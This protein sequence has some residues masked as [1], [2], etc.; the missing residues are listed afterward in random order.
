MMRHRKK[1]ARRQ[2]RI[3]QEAAEQARQYK[4][5]VAQSQQ[6][7]RARLLRAR[8][9]CQGLQ[10]GVPFQTA[11]TQHLP[12]ST[13]APGRSQR[14]TCGSVSSTLLLLLL[15]VVHGYAG[16]T[17]PFIPPVDGIRTFPAV[18]LESHRPVVQQARQSEP[19]GGLGGLAQLLSRQSAPPE[20]SPSQS[21]AT[22]PAPPPA[23]AGQS[24]PVAPPVPPPAPPA[25][26]PAP[27]G[28]AS[29]VVTPVPQPPPP[30][31]PAPPPPPPPPPPPSAPPQPTAGARLAPGPSLPSMTTPEG[32]RYPGEGTT[33]VKD[34]QGGFTWCERSDMT[35]AVKAQ[36]K[37]LM[38]RYDKVFARSLKDLGC[39]TGEM[40]PARIE[41]VHDR[42]IWQPQRQHS[43][44]ELQIQ[45]EKCA[46]LRDAGII[47]PS[48]STKYAMNVTM[49]AKKDANGQWTDRRYCCDARP[50]NAATVPN[51][52][53][54]PTP[55]QLFQ[56][57]GGSP[58]ISKM[59]CRAAFNQI[60]L[61]REDQEKT[62]F[63]WREK[64]W[65]YTRNLY[66][67]RNATGQFQM[68]IDHEL[69][70]HGLEGF[71]MAFVDDILVFS[72]TAE[73]H[74]QHCE[75]VFRCLM[76]CGL[77]LHPEKTI[78]AAEEVEFL[79]HMCSAMGVRPMDAKCAAIMA[80]Q[81]PTN[82]T[83]LQA[84]LGLCNYYR[85]Y[86]PHFS[87]IA[88]PLNQLTRKGI[89]WGEQTWQ[90]EHQAVLDA[91]KAHF[92]Q[93]GLILRRLQPG[94]PIILHTDFSAS[95][96]SGVLGQ[97]D[98]DGNEY[99]VA[100]VSRSLN[101]HERNYISY[102]GEMR[103]ACW[104][105]QAMRP[106]LH[107]VQFTLVTDH[108]PLLWLMENTGA[109]S[110]GVYQRWQLIMSQYDFNITHRPGALHQNADAL[111]RMPRPSTADGTGSRMDEEDDPVPPKPQLVPY[112]R[113]LV[114]GTAA[115]LSGPI[116]VLLTRSQAQRERLHA[117]LAVGS[118]SVLPTAEELLAGNNGTLTDPVDRCPVEE[119]LPTQ[120]ATR[121]LV[122]HANRLAREHRVALNAIACEPPRAAVMERPASAEQDPVTVALNSSLN[123]HHFL[124]K[125][126]SE[127]LVVVEYGS[128][129]AG[130]E[131]VLRAGW[132]VRAY[133]VAD[134][135]PP[136]GLKMLRQRLRALEIEYP[137]QLRSSAVHSP[138]NQLPT[139][140]DV[141]EAMLRNLGAAKQHQWLV[142]GAAESAVDPRAR[143][144]LQLIGALQRLQPRLLPG[145]FV[146]I[147]GDTTADTAF[148][149]GFLVDLACLGQRQHGLATLYTSLGESKRLSRMTGSHAWASP[150]AELSGLLPGRTLA[151]L[152]SPLSDPYLRCDVPGARPVVLPPGDLFGS[153]PPGLI[154]AEPLTAQQLELVLGLS[155]S[156][157]AS[158][159]EA[160][161]RE[162][163]ASGPSFP[164]AS[165][166]FAFSQALQR[167]YMTPH[168][169]A[170]LKPT[171]A[172][173]QPAFPLGGD[174]VPPYTAD[175]P[176]AFVALATRPSPSLFSCTTLVSE[177]AEVL[178]GQQ[179]ANLTD[180][181]LDLEMRHLLRHGCYSE[182]L[183]PKEQQRITKQ[184][185]SY[186]ESGGRLLRYMPNG[187]VREVPEPAQRRD[188]IDRAHSSL[189]HFG[190][191][192]T[193]GLLQCG[194]W[195]PGM[196]RDVSAVVASCKLCDQVNAAGN[197]RPE[198]LQPLPIRGP[199]YRWGCDLAGP[200]PPTKRGNV[201]VMI[202]VEHFTKHIELVA[203][204]NKTADETARVLLERVLC[205]FSAPAEV[206]TDR[207]QEWEGAFAAL[208]EQ[209]LIDHR[210]TSPN[211]PQADGAAERVVQT[212][213][214][215][216]R[217]YCAEQRSAADWD[218]YLPWLQLGYN[219]SPQASTG[220]SPYLLLY[221][222]QPVIPPAVRE[223][224]TEP[225]DPANETQFYDHLTRRAELFQ[226]L[227][228]EAAGNLLIAQHRDTQRYARVR[229]GGYQPRIERFEPGDYVYV[230]ARNRNST[231]QPP[232][233]DS[234]LRVVQVSPAGVVTLRGRCGTERKE[235]VSQL[236]P[237]HLPD[238]D[239]IVDPR[240]AVPPADLACEVCGFPDQEEVMLL[241]DGC[242]TGWHMHCLRPQLTQV[243]S[244]TWV[245]PDCAAAG[246]T[247]EQIDAKP[248]PAAPETQPNIFPNAQQRRRQAAAA[249]LDGRA[250]RRRVKDP[251]ALSAAVCEG[252]A[253]YLGPGSGA[254]QY[255]VTYDNG[256][257][258]RMTMATLRKHL[259]PKSSAGSPSSRRRRTSL[260]G[261]TSALPDIWD[262]GSLTGARAAFD[263]LVPAAEYPDGQVAK[264]V[265]LLPRGLAHLRRSTRAGELTP[266]PR[267]AHGHEVEALVRAVDF[268]LC[269]GVLDPWAGKGTV[270]RALQQKGYRVF[271]NDPF[272]GHVADRHEDP[273]QPGFYLRVQDV[274]PFDAVVSSP[275]AAAVDLAL[276]LAARFAPIVAM[277]VAAHYVTDA[278]EARR[279]YLRSLTEAG[280]LALILGLPKGVWGRRCVW[281]VV[282]ASRGLRDQL[283]RAKGQAN[284]P[285]VMV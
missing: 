133:H 77:R 100:C 256:A 274:W 214:K 60:P 90:P 3:M 230:L 121:Q 238:L 242:G 208:C 227:M 243:P 210:T 129:A 21:A 125:A 269:A 93:E 160:L 190:S 161:R 38:Q 80:L 196:S 155:G 108:A 283:L 197:V 201:M 226:R 166:V 183:S 88:A 59:D 55:E 116:Q 245:C 56:R 271:S 92:R 222:A 24:S 174:G 124:E 28:Q 185:S 168:H 254:Q 117:A 194:F 107:G 225:L 176:A 247:V 5:Q 186:R 86:V 200:L 110:A 250:V 65:M 167:A 278:H 1:L 18:H 260:A 66:G 128:H 75:A 139:S 143:R 95:G 111:S 150:V 45:E 266:E 244:G 112:P 268:G 118:N 130:L 178:D 205:R 79:G 267:Q 282:F 171:Y 151:P 212:T 70:R 52:Y 249:A 106:Y 280:R 25:P 147:A 173:D 78:I 253:R 34:E 74:V 251:V 7:L 277:H 172:A 68:I 27:D 44:L 148:G 228:P 154:E 262:F 46:E 82:L 237:C 213:K 255:E 4:Q 40:G 141:T 23:Q 258:E 219:C 84:L 149:N 207:G 218:D 217:K 264:F 284:G 177:V 175:R 220:H 182:Q 57:I 126:L 62:S 232:T 211:H 36:F 279:R 14:W 199:L 138:F 180:P 193:L 103:A 191:R 137:H 195:W 122:Q 153:P 73:E 83:E 17:P 158:A 42:P 272:D 12:T 16:S 39:Y 189:G 101:A 136:A 119:L 76:E 216:L 19:V 48:S 192:R 265:N 51:R 81:P 85:C 94:R 131:A 20:P 163:L 104:A 184:A 50:L 99:L 30:P 35:P 241:C 223:R 140:G 15:M 2:R 221:G 157:T 113:A 98:D 235:H 281:L 114:T 102:K 170:T 33:F 89:V 202:C 31:P 142:V 26:P 71:A 29:P 164:A 87:E 145:Y 146:Q 120:L 43:P 10:P 11:A 285:W 263:Q 234:V 127:G 41:L 8:R 115:S 105:M 135:L 165:Q 240:L 252:V 69:R 91:I 37:E 179:P 13:I 67:L 270:V 123:S 257:V 156:V 209:C 109:G 64:L 204:P 169:M 162:L 22:P 187:T 206:L 144:I 61:A 261:S 276:P 248:V 229:A 203:L 246:I 96:I 236:R 259:V 72:A 224:V 233:R 152:A 97:L 54:P 198:Q 181:C 134:A 9:A 6:R 239:P 273:L 47:V 49:P 231:L 188:I 53:A 132:H 159:P 275:W 63:W 32:K 215:A 58:W